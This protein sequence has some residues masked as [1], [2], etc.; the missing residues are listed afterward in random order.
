MF[1]G[2]S[3]GW[4][5]AAA[6]AMAVIPVFGWRMVLLMGFLPI[7]LVPVL[8]IYLPESIRFLASKG[9][10]DDAVKE[11]RKV[12]KAARVAPFNWTQKTLV[13]P[14]V[15]AAGSVRDLFSPKLI[16]MTILVWMT[17]LVTIMTNTG[18]GFWVPTLMIKAGFSMVRSYS[19]SA[20]QSIG[21]SVGA[22]LIGTSMDKFGRKGGLVMT[23]V[24]GGISVWLFGNVGSYLALFVIGAAVGLFQLSTTT[25]LH[26][27]TGEIYPTRIR[28]TGIGWALTVGRFGSIVAPILGGLLQMAGLTPRQ[29]FMVFSVP[30]FVC[31]FLVLL[32]RVNVKD[33]ALETVTARLTAE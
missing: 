16:T 32:Y 17:Y 1:A 23:Y 28:S 26:V 21:A 5:L 24:L 22:F 13:P 31:A 4:V 30:C 19:F 25:A 33:Q 9:R 8:A 29:F 6:V 3:L 14:A 27:V 10:Y 7:L 12:E 15:E 11:I 20:V 18:L 2:F